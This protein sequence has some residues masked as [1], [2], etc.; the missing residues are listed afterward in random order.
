MYL[1]LEKSRGDANG[2]YIKNGGPTID[3]IYLQNNSTVL[4]KYRP[5]SV[6][7]IIPFLINVD[8]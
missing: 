5:Y 2:G 3:S 7:P 1:R 8:T 6:G 4:R